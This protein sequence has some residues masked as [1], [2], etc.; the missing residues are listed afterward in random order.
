MK[1]KVGTPI[2]VAPEIITG[3]YIFIHLSLV[4]LFNVMSGLLDALCMYYY[5]A[6]LHF[7]QINL[8]CLKQKLSIQILIFLILYLNPFQRKPKI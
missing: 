5:V 8:I 3:E 2:Y 4:I 6:V 1:S 7:K